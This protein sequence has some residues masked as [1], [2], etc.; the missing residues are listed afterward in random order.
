[1]KKQPL[2]AAAK[3]KGTG[4][5]AEASGKPSAPKRAKAA[6]GSASAATASGSAS[7]PPSLSSG[8]TENK[9]SSHRTLER[10]NELLVCPVSTEP[11]T[12]PILLPC[13]HV[14]DYTSI[15]G[16]HAASEVTKAAPVCPLCRELMLRDVQ[17]Y[18]ISLVHSQL[19]AIVH[20]DQKVDPKTARPTKSKTN[21]KFEKITG[22]AA[23]ASGSG[24]ALGPTVESIQQKVALKAVAYHRD[25]EVQRRWA[26]SV[27]DDVLIPYIDNLVDKSPPAATYKIEKE[28]YPGHPVTP[29]QETALKEAFDATFPWARYGS[30]RIM[31]FSASSYP[32]NDRKK[33][34]FEF[35]FPN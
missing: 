18:D 11:M 16:I 34:K 28:Y 13:Q 14:F 23:A 33:V 7:A 20:P 26:K 5:P 10:V 30:I 12:V 31:I 17:A 32:Y 6:S 9:A 35:T 21:E 19:F 27:I 29:S 24:A 25:V 2:L 8:P 3:R 22:V 1:M 15:L 4:K